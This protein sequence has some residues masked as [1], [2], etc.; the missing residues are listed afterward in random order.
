MVTFIPINED[1]FDGFLEESMTHFIEDLQTSENIS[2]EEA[3]FQAKSQ[4]STV[5]PNG[6][7]SRGHYF[8]H[9]VDEDGLVVGYFWLAFKEEKEKKDAFIF[10]I[11]IHEDQRGKGYGKAAMLKG[12]EIAKE[13]GADKLWLH[14]IA[15]NHVA[16]QLYQKLGYQIIKI[17]PMKDGSGDAS[18][19]MAK[20]LSL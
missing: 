17:Y 12:E 2:L 4:L 13:N 8:F 3:E 15:Q 1:E 11:V 20:S 18:Y 6:K 9:V 10:D 19:N 14:V 5:L 16:L 7:D